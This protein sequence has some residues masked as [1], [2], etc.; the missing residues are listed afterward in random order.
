LTAADYFT[1]WIDIVPTRHTIDVVII[2]FLEN[3]IFS[4]FGCPRRIMTNNATYFKSKRMIKFC[5]DYNI[6]L[7]HF[8]SYYPHDNGLAESSNKILIRIIKKLLHENKKACHK[9]LI[10][11]LWEDRINLKM[12]IGTSSLQLV[13]GT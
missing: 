7:S 12:S 3:N 10:F 8:T 9:K 6:I 13:Y 11:S 2:Q 1:K 4:R 5:E